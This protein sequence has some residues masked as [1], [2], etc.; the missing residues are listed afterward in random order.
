MM[1]LIEYN[2]ILSIEIKDKEEEDVLKQEQKETYKA[3]KPEYREQFFTALDKNEFLKSLCLVAYYSGMRIGE[4][5]GLR[6]QDVD[7][8]NNILSI[9]HA[10]TF[11]VTYDNEGNRESK[12]TI[13]SSTKS[14]SS[15]AKLPMSNR[16]VETLK[17]WRSIQT[18][19]GKKL[20]I[21]FTG[22]KNFIFCNDCGEMRTYHGT[23]N[24]LKSF[25]K[26]NGLDNKGIHF[27]AIRHT[28]GDVLREKN[29]SIYEIQK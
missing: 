10:I 29:W 23:R 7:F 22:P 4:I 3:I 6:W 12:K 28:F 27:H 13:L 15:K 24:I 9:E 11:E 14:V 8:K 20:N 18:K 5:L 16:L 19:K 1:R 26:A 25:L 21:N 2:P 17:E